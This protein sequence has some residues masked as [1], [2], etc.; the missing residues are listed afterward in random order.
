[1]ILRYHSSC[2]RRRPL[3][4][5]DITPQGNGRVPSVLLRALALFRPAAPGRLTRN[6]PL[7]A[8]TSRRLS[9]SGADPLFPHQCVCFMAQG[10]VF[11]LL[12]DRSIIT[13]IWDLSRKNRKAAGK[14]I[15]RP[16]TP[17]RPANAAHHRQSGPRLS[18]RGPP[19]RLQAQGSRFIGLVR[20]PLTR[21]SKWQWLPVLRPVEPIS[22]MCWPLKTLSP[23][24]T[25]RL[26]LW[27]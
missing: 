3:S 26:L 27:P 22:A 10:F 6:V 14:S 12:L 7:P 9:E 15:L 20:S 21:T 8:H 13:W 24:L 25:R 17:A 19:K 1:M 23:T 11:I 16:A 5:T 4:V 18:C 2:R